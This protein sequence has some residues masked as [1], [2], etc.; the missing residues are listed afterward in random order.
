L[1]NAQVLGSG[2]IPLGTPQIIFSEGSDTILALVPDQYCLR[3]VH[4]NPFNPSTT[5]RFELPAGKLVT[6][7]I[8]D[9]AGREVAT[10]VD[11]FRQPGSH[12]VTFDA[13]G[14]PSGLYFARL[15][16]GSFTHTRKLILL[17]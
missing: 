3:E 17:K 15:Q 2:I 4:P 6:L 14:L 5:I 9:T 16:A 8:Y 12:Q 1:N 13:T 10:L 11:G 7:R